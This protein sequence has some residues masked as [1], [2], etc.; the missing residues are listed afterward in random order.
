ML[1][2]NRA[3]RDRAGSWVSRSAPRSVSMGV[4]ICFL[5]IQSVGVPIQLRG[6]PIQSRGCPELSSELT[7]LVGVPN[8]RTEFPNCRIELPNGGCPELTN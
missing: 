8:C 4:P 3:G 2:V 1:Q 7:N 6:C 5:P